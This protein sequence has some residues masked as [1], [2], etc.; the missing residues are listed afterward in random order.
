LDIEGT[1]ARRPPSP[2][3]DDD[4][5]DDERTQ[6]LSV[7]AASLPDFMHNEL[8]DEA[9]DFFDENEVDFWLLPLVKAS[10]GKST[11]FQ[12]DAVF[13]NQGDANSQ[14]RLV[15]PAPHPL[16]TVNLSE[17]QQQVLDMVIAGKSVFFT[18]YV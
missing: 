4:V 2:H 8:P 14:L 9:E 10:P 5:D 17:E 6:M 12:Q 15:P 16:D 3:G 18:G 13:S 7:I 11:S 1:H